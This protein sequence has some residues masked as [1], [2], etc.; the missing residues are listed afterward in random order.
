MQRVDSAVGTYADAPKIK[1][2]ADAENKATFTLTGEDHTL[3]NSLRYMLIRKC[4]SL[5][6]APPLKPGAPSR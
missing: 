5:P 6:A 3:G 4:A 1:C 2:D